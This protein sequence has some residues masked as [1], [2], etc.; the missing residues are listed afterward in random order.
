MAFFKPKHRAPLPVRDGECPDPVLPETP[1]D[2]QDAGWLA[3]SFDLRQGLDVSEATPEAWTSELFA[4]TVAPRS[5]GGKG[6]GGAA[7]A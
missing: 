1:P 4:P 7:G 6:G 5:S 2:V 3:S